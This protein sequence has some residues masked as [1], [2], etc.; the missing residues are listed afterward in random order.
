M[1]VKVTLVDPILVYFKSFIS[2]N[3]NKTL[4][5]EMYCAMETNNF[6]VNMQKPYD[7]NNFH[8]NLTQKTDN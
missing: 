5:E 7:F 8:I 4:R 1:C 2:E 3:V 6:F